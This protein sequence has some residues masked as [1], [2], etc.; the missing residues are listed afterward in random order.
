MFFYRTQYSSK[1]LSH[2][3]S[4]CSHSYLQSSLGEEIEAQIC[5]LLMIRVHDTACI[6]QICWLKFRH[7]YIYHASSPISVLGGI[8]IGNKLCWGYCFKFSWLLKWWVVFVGV[9]RLGCT[10]EPLG[11]LKN[12]IAVENLCGWHLYFH[13]YTSDSDV[14]P[15]W[16][17]T[18]LD[19]CYSTEVHWPAVLT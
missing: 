6:E 18:A 12:R 3:L 15:N 5:N 4:F 16:R 10:L 13:S 14:Q 9:L 19:S 7:I 8:Y 2:T 11:E 1:S 17:S